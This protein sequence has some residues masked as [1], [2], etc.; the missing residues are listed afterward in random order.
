MLA[1]ETNEA[2]Q[3]PARERAGAPPFTSGGGTESGTARGSRAPRQTG[4][5][6]DRGGRPGG[7]RYGRRPPKVCAFCAD[8]TKKIDYKDVG[9]L[10][11]FVTDRGKI[12]SQRKTGTCARHQRRVAVAVKRARHIALLPFSSEERRG[13]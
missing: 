1:D 8:K 3:A 12:Q 7:R 6:E 10:R 11:R 9:L 5:R 4:G 13:R 2:V